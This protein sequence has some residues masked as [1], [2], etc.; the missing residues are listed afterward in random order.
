M[1][2]ATLSLMARNVDSVGFIAHMLACITQIENPAD[3]G[4]IRGVAT[5]NETRDNGTRLISILASQ[6]ILRFVDMPT[7]MC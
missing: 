6:L 2:A 7:F 1:T 5:V 3:L 4:N